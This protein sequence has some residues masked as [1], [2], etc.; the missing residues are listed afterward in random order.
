M[1]FWRRKEPTIDSVS[2]DTNGWSVRE[3][4]DTHRMWMTATRDAVLLRHFAERPSYTYD[5]SNIN[6]ARS[7]YNVQSAEN[8]GAMISVD[9]VKADGVDV[10]KGIFKYRSPE[11][12][13][14][15]MYYVGVL[16]MLY[17]DFSLQINTESLEVGPTGSRDAGVALIRNDN[18]PG[19]D[20][21]VHVENIEE[22]FN[23]MRNKPVL[24][25]LADDEQYDAAFPDHPL[26]KVRVL[27]A[28]ILGSLKVANEVHHSKPYCV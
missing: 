18:P 5:F 1:V 8:G 17:R 21:P 15:A 11:P 24:K 23:L 4:S 27:Q 26:S 22:L 9:F 10:M 19:D 28:R 13:S 6:A 12:G 25:T 3:Q 7:F 16:T 20:E 14:M 2:F